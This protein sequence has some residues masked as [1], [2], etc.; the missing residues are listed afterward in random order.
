MDTPGYRHYRLHTNVLTA[1]SVGS[2][3]PE[4]SEHEL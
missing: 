2:Q 1:P 3:M 4:N